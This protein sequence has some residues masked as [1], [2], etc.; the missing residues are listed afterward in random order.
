MSTAVAS[1]AASRALAGNAGSPHTFDRRDGPQ[2]RITPA[3]IVRL[4]TGSG[5]FNVPLLSLLLRFSALAAIVASG[6]DILHRAAVHHC[7]RRTAAGRADRATPGYRGDRWLCR[8]VVHRAPRRRGLAAG[9]VVAAAVGG[10]LRRWYHHHPLAL[11]RRVELRPQ[12]RA[13]HRL[14]RRRRRP[15]MLLVPL[16]PWAPETREGWPLF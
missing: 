9:G 15:G 6:G 4:A 5:R 1:V 11:P 16:L 8:C 10:Q 13:Q 3:K 14:C 7:L 2:T 12:R